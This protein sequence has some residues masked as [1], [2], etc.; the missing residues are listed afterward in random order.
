MAHWPD[1]N[2]L[3][4]SV[5]SQR[6]NLWSSEVHIVFSGPFLQNTCLLESDASSSRECSLDDVHQRRRPHSYGSPVPGPVVD[7]GGGG[8]PSWR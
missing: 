4:L 2:V 1:V 8:S 5:G 3:K 6:M 7:L